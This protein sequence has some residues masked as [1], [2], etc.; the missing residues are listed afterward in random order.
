MRHNRILKLS[1]ISITVAVVIGCTGSS[2]QSSS[3]ELASQQAETRSEFQN[4]IVEQIDDPARARK[5]AQLSVERDQLISQHAATIEEYSKR[6]EA[7]TLDYSAEHKDLQDLI[8]E[9][10]VERREA[11]TEFLALMDRM[12]ATVTEKEW[13]K[14][15]KFELKKLNPRTLSY[16]AGDH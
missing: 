12:K 10:N 13:E 16:P 3:D 9:Y 11:Q 4:L 6:L 14:L 5:F 8:Q 15:A 1:L 7:L 2:R